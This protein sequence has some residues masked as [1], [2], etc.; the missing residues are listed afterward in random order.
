MSKKK[1]LTIDMNVGETFPLR[2]I[3]GD[4][5]VT[6]EDCFVQTVQAQIPIMVE[7]DKGTSHHRVEASHQPVDITIKGA[8]FINKVKE[9]K[10]K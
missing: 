3:T 1:A 9:I 5:E 8:G 6:L 7:M 4:Y 2:I 10:K